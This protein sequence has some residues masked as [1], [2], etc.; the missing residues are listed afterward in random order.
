MTVNTTHVPE[1]GIATIRGIHGNLS[2]VRCEITDRSR[3]GRV[4][5][6]TVRPLESVPAD[7]LVAL[8]VS[9][10]IAIS[11]RFIDGEPKY[12]IDTETVALDWEQSMADSPPVAP[13]QPD[14]GRK[15]LRN[16]KGGSK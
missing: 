5:F 8:A 10:N 6:W 12:K 3:R 16:G 15:P 4:F 11:L 9:R 2:P 13:E 1:C 7:H 14:R